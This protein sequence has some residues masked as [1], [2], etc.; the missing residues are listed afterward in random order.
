M[1]S[2]I[3]AHEIAFSQPS[4]VIP[5]GSHRL[6]GDVRPNI[7]LLRG[8][9]SQEINFI[10]SAAK[11]R[12][13]PAKSV[14]TFQD[15]PADHLLLL[16][17]GRARYF[18]ETPSGKKLIMIWITPGHAFGGVALASRTSNYLL[19][20]ETV[21]DSVVLVWDGATIRGLA[22]RFPRLL[23]NAIAIAVD[24]L[25]WY[26]AAHAA[27]C[28]QT[29]RQRLAS[30]LLGY[31]SSIGQ[32]ISGGIEFDITNEELANAAN[33]SAYTT[34]R[35]LNEWQRIGAIRKVRGKIVVRSTE[36]LFLRVA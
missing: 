2:N 19:S 28:S 18:F 6:I 12:R 25:S 27:L 33:I 11:S 1:G 35:I 16:W 8:L 24:Y 21:R 26:I 31:T 13:V 36:R 32:R 29:A 14:M 20:T 7:E 10:L 17:K 9:K 15:E 3:K 23:E 22:R 30:V 34:S 4:V 5:E